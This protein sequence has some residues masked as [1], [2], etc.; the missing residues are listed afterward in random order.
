MEEDIA[1]LTWLG[2]TE[3]QA[4]VYLALLQMG[5]AGAED[6]SRLS[7]V[8]RQ[9]VYR[10]AA[11]LQEMG[12]LETE[13]ASPTQFIA[14][15]VADALK[16]MV[17]IKT[18]EFDEVRLHTRNIIK[19]YNQSDLTCLK[20]ND[21]SYFTVVS[22]NDCLRKLCS[23]VESATKSVKI[24]SNKKRFCQGFSIHEDVLKNALKRKVCIKVITERADSKTFPKWITEALEAYSP[25]FELRTVDDA[26]ATAVAIYDNAKLCMAITLQSDIVY[27]SQLWSN[28]DSLITVSQAYFDCAWLRSTFYLQKK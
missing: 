4:K 23:A 1:T 27:G 14:V 5:S 3:R 15:P 21:K 10:V 8:H 16:I 24:V 13:V 25:F 6:I 20:S 26:L 12:L 18:K 7:S 28:N 22:G 2:L 19:R 9:E 17:N 11:R